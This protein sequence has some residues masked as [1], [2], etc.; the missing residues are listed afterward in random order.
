MLAACAPAATEPLSRQLQ[1]DRGTGNDQAPTEAPTEESAPH[2]ERHGGWLDEIDISVV[3]GASAI[4]QLQAGTI[5]FFSFGLAS[6]VYPAIGIGPCH[7]RNPS[8]LITVLALNPAVFTDT[9]RLK[10]VLEPQD[11]RSIEL[12]IDR[13]YINQEIYRAAHC[14]SCCPSPRNWWNTP[15]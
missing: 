1:H 12:A 5:D 9:A 6:G 8:A 10:S 11:P 14:P 2:T 3:D 13:N 4:S 15:T 7:D